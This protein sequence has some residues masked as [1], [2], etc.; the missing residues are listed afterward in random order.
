[1]THR[2]L[3]ERKEGGGARGDTHENTEER[4]K[5]RREREERGRRNP[6]PTHTGAEMFLHNRAQERELGIESAT[7]NRREESRKTP[8][9][10]FTLHYLPSPV[11]NVM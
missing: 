10:Y 11:Y 8:L 9:H 2:S 5:E 4:P 3:A 1:V 6:N 7:Q